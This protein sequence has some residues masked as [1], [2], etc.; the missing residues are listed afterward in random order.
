MCNC[1]SGMDI[2]ERCCPIYYHAD[3]KRC[4]A[5]VDTAYFHLTND[6]ETYIKLE[7]CKTKKQKEKAIVS[8]LHNKL[9]IISR[10]DKDN[11]IRHYWIET[12]LTSRPVYTDDE[13]S[14]E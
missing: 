7:K 1:H 8:Y 9:K 13:A 10:V 14:K 2:R 12:E 6:Y 3:Y 5:R 11:I 4:V